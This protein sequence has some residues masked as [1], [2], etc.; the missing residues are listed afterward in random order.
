MT[1]NRSA[2]T[3]DEQIPLL[4]RYK[5]LNLNMS[6]LD[7]VVM[8]LKRILWTYR[9]KGPSKLAY[10]GGKFAYQFARDLKKGEYAPV[11][12]LKSYAT[13]VTPKSYLWLG[14]ENK[15]P[16][17]YISTPEVFLEL[18]EGY[19]NVL[20]N[21]FV[22][23]EANQDFDDIVPEL[24]GTIEF[25]TFRPSSE[26]YPD[27]LRR[28]VADQGSITV[29]P[30]DDNQGNGFY[31]LS[32]V[33]G[34]LEISTRELSPPSVEALLDQLDGYIVSELINQHAYADEIYPDAINTLRILTAIDPDTL[35]PRVIRAAH[36]FGSD[37][38]APTDNF[39]AGGYCANVNVE[40]GEIGEIATVGN[41]DQRVLH[42]THPKTGASV[43]GVELPYWEE[44]LETVLELA[45][46]HRPARLVGWDVI[47]SPDGPRVIEGNI[48][49]GIHLIQADAGLLE[50]PPA[51]RLLE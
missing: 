40:T 4:N 22:F 18:N 15:D 35:E 10:M 26:K 37:E 12:V 3:R 36:R 20:S 11:T 33:D 6:V 24:Y 43:A 27:D 45:D 38:S 39:A 23:T 25:G 47:I 16:D 34:E 14:L 29:K 9:S 28:L 17:Q 42:R 7:C 48:K 8:L 30:I 19:G 49:P 41:D 13:G 51:E 5:S 32:V 1:R 31:I 44:A 46:K 50:E 21:K 2:V